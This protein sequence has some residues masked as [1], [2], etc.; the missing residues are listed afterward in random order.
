MSSAFEELVCRFGT[1]LGAAPQHPPC[2]PELPPLPDASLDVLV[3]SA[4]QASAPFASVSSFVSAS[5]SES[6]LLICSDP[7]LGA[8]CPCRL[9][10]LLRL[11]EGL[12][13]RLLEAL[14]CARMG[15]GKDKDE[16]N[17]LAV[18]V[19]PGGG[20]SCV[21]VGA[22]DVD[23]VRQLVMLVRHAVLALRAQCNAA[24]AAGAGAEAAAEAAS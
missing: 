2:V 3:A 5:A 7:A 10:A 15:E 19:L 1:A 16:G 6:I 12:Y 23:W 11:A 4:A 14:L 22:A 17:E 24:G 8:N 20:G 9:R 21:Q 13:I 18:P